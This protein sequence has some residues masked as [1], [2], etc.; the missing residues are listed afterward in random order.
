MAKLNT[1][2]S[3]TNATIT[4]EG[5][6]FIIEEFNSKDES[7][8]VF[9]LTDKLNGVVDIKGVKLA[10]DTTSVLESDK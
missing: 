5:G 2:L 6:D 8:G 1:K 10:Y 4:K 3:F 9:N 7:V